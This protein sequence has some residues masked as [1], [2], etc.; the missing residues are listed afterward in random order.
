M[1]TIFEDNFNSYTDGDLNGQGSWSGDS[2]FQIQ[3]T[4]TYE[5][6]KAVYINNPGDVKNIE[7]TGNQE[8][9]GRITVYMRQG[10]TSVEGIIFY[11][12][13]GISACTGVK[14]HSDGNI[15]ALITGSQ[16]ITLQSYNSNQWYCVEIEWQGTGLSS[17]VRFRVDKGTWT[18]WK[19]PFDYWSTGPNKVKFQA[20]AN[21]VDGYYDYIA[22]NPVSSSSSSSSSSYSSSSCSFSSSYSSSSSI[23][24]SSSSSS[25][26]SSSSSSISSSSSSVSSSSSSSSSLSSSSISFSS[27]SSSSSSKSSSSSSFSSC[28]SSFSSSSSSSSSLSSSS[29][30]SSFSSSSSSSS[31][32]CSSSFSSSSSSFSSSS[33]SSAYPGELTKDY[34]I[35]GGATQFRTSIWF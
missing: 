26:F 28:S 21:T 17:E 15:K 4:T 14:F 23:S 34:P 30:S 22:E 32:S 20:C 9:P 24:S 19:E 33:S 7:K 6:A 13:E 25:S 29:S 11:L 35:G 12:F 2:N 16:W 5:G 10:S 8:S 31:S 1:A 18:D 27:C 3:G